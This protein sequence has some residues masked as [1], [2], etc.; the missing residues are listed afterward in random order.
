MYPGG[1]RRKSELLNIG[2]LFLK[3]KTSLKIILVIGKKE[4]YISYLPEFGA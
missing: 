3:V 1:Q 2:F 4:N